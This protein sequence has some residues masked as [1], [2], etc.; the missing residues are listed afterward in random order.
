MNDLKRLHYDIQ[1]ALSIKVDNLLPVFS[2]SDH[3]FVLG[4]GKSE[5]VAKEGALKLKEITYM[6][7]EGY[8]TSSLKH[9]PFALLNDNFPVII[10]APDDENYAKVENAYEE[11]KSRNAPIVFIT[12]KQN[13]NKGW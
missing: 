9:G 1:T 10:L 2:K 11:I 13:K 5:T 12:D 4:K 8:S 7:S 6:H 3:C